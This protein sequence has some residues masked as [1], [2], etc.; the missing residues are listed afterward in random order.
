MEQL[1]TKFFNKSESAHFVAFL[2]HSSNYIDS[3]FFKKSG[4]FTHNFIW[5][6]LSSCQNLEKTD[7]IPR[8]CSDGRTGRFYL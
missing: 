6:C 5:L 2:V 8:K 4:P 3:F 7:P 1:I